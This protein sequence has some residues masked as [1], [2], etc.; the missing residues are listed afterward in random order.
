[1]FQGLEAVDSFV[2]FGLNA[3]NTYTNL[4]NKFDEINATLQQMNFEPKEG[5][6]KLKIVENMKEQSDAAQAMMPDGL[7]AAMEPKTKPEETKPEE[8]KPTGKSLK[9]GGSRKKRKKYKRKTRKR[10]L[11]KRH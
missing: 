8:T 11:K 7:N 5:L 1:M 2:D 3:Y 9:K 4:T 6:T 10:A